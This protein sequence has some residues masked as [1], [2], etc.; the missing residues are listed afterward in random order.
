MTKQQCLRTLPKMDD[1]LRAIESEASDLPRN[2]IK[3]VIQEELGRHRESLAAGKLDCCNQEELLT[4]IRL[5]L[6][7]QSRSHLRG[8]VN[9]TG[10]IFH[11]NLGRAR[12]AQECE[13][14]LISVGCGYSNLE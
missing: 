12:L 6:E 9:A 11:T 10:I 2:L 7:R 5:E 1:L 8:V 3:S 14:M 4:C 13:M